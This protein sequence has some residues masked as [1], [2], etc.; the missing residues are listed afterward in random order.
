[1]TA[2]D[3]SA[4]DLSALDL[5]APDLSARDLS[6]PDLSNPDL[7]TTD[8]S[9]LSLSPS[10]S[11]L[12]TIDD[13]TSH[14]KPPP[15]LFTNPHIASE[16]PPG[17]PPPPLPLPTNNLKRSSPFQFGSR[18][19]EQGDD[20]YSFNAWDHVTP[21]PLYTTHATQ[22]Y[23]LQRASPVSDY[24]RTRFNA[25]PAKWWN[26]FYRHNTT[27][28][29]KDRKWLRQEFPVLAAVTQAG[30]GPKTVLEI[31][32]GAGNT[33]FPI[34]AGNANDGLTIWACDFSKKAVELIR[35]NAAFDARVM[36]A[37]VWDV[38]SATESLPRGLRAGS[39]DVVL[40]VFVFS[41]LAPGQWAQ[42]VRNVWEA[43]RPGG[44]VCLR[45]YG[46]GDLAQLK[47]YRCWMQGRFRKRC[48]TG[49]ELPGS[50]GDD[51]AVAAEGP[52]EEDQAL[53]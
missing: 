11:D 17:V 16:A 44:E 43:L 33:A 9:T 45:D 10:P 42:A 48:E 51:G 30:A 4:H 50:A 31:G 20:I 27:H 28:F 15:D 38:A 5:S 24:D 41:A 2:T 34:L 53:S 18:Y 25:D 1:M 8:L 26:Q 49:K 14:A 29:F 21:D 23:A 22:Q 35:A 47:M 3:L 46:R 39:V 12:S 40:M 6:T 36:R 32:A 13:D 7:S 19:L 37:E 52:F